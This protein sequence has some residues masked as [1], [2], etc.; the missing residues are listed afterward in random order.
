M[1]PRDLIRSNAYLGPGT[2]SVGLL[3][4]DAGTNWGVPSQPFGVVTLNPQV[5]ADIELR[6]EGLKR[7]IRRRLMSEIT[8]EFAALNEGLLRELAR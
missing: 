2:Y 8:S 5:E 6:S 7:R 4:R 3:Y 1:D